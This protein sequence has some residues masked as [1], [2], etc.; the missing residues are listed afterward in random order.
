MSVG[1][2][3]GLH[4]FTWIMLGMYVLLVTIYVQDGQ[5]VTLLLHGGLLSP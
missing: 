1:M 4:T 5:H 2:G 3:K